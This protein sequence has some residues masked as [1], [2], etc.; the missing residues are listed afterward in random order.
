VTVYG[1]LDV[2]FQGTEDLGGGTR[3]FFTA[4]FQL[5][6][7]DATLSGNTGNGLFNRQT[8]VG[9]GQKGIGQAAI[10]TQY[11]PIHLAVGRTDPGQQNNMLGNVIYATNASQGSGQTTAAYTVRY[12]NS[13]TLQTDRFA[14]FVLSG[15]Y[16]NNNSNSNNTIA[17]GSTNSSTG[18]TA[19]GTGLSQQNNTSWGVGGN[20]VWQK[21]NLDVVYQSSLNST[22]YLGTTQ[23]TAAGPAAAV[24]GTV[25]APANPLGTSL[26]FS[27]FSCIPAHKTIASIQPTA[28]PN[29]KMV[30]STNVY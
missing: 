22:Y 19:A 7:T 5:N 17:I 10:G 8:F 1:I 4:E 11:T 23:P 30:V 21:L 28:D 13:I 25:N 15:I 14:G 24:P 3:A 20:Y 12:N 9:I 18:A 6:A 26:I 27:I 2:G 29:E 16:S